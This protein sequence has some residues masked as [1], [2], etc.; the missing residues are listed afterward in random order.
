MFCKF[1][2]YFDRQMI[3]LKYENEFV[4]IVNDEQ[5]GDRSIPI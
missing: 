1:Q 2:G 3:K 5:S 4:L